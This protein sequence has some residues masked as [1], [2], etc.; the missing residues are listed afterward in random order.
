MTATML[1]LLAASYAIAQTPQEYVAK[2]E[3]A[4]DESDVVGA[5]SYY[6]KAAEAGY[7]PAQ[8]RLAYLLDKSERNEEAV[9]WYKKAAEQGNAEAE[10]GLAGMY[11]SGDGIAQ[12]NAEA[13]RLFRSSAGKGYAPA[14]HVMAAA[15]EQGDLGLRIDYELAREWLEKGVQLNDRWAIKRMARAYDKGEL[16]LR[17]DRQKAAQ[18][19][20]QL[21]DLKQDSD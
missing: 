11:A 10:H 6:R 15:Y 19:E 20:Q 8:S 12:D 5:M 14:I 16:G 9:T 2:A 7:A 4:F 17:I 3:K 13:L 1:A 18:L 21:A